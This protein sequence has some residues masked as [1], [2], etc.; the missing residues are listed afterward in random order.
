MLLS[1]DDLQGKEVDRLLSAG[2]MKSLCGNNYQLVGK[3]QK[4]IYKT[5][6][7]IRPS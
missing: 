7:G 6:E 3:R 2:E 4:S 1:R 5:V